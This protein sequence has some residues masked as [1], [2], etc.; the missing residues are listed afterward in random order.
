[1]RESSGQTS[2]STAFAGKRTNCCA[3]APAAAVRP[4]HKRQCCN[5]VLPFLTAHLLS[6]P[7]HTHLQHLV[8]ACQDSLPVVAQ[9]LHLAHHT[10]NHQQAVLEDR[11]DVVWNRPGVDEGGGMN[12]PICAV[13]AL[14][15]G[16]VDLVTGRS[17]H[18]GDGWRWRKQQTNKRMRAGGCLF[19]V[20]SCS[21]PSGQPT[22]SAMLTVCLLG[23]PRGAFAMI[24]VLGLFSCPQCVQFQQRQ[25]PPNCCQVL[26]LPW[27]RGHGCTY[28]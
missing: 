18:P 13:A 2:C 10:L 24:E 11:H 20:T 14:Y 22:T 5:C 26:R 17:K 7:L 23:S 3:S 28:L 15:D 12:S 25:T 21:T 19:I 27:P 9:R 4:S 16:E 1:M 8:C 6:V